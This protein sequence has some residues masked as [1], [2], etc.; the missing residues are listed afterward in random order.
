MKQSELFADAL[1]EFYET[2]RADLRVERDDGYRGIENVA[3]YFTTAREF[4]P[5]EKRA[6]KF[7]RGKILDAGCGAGRHSL[8][9]QKRGL[10]V[11]AVDISPR[12]AAL[13]RARGV[14]DARV[15]NL[16][17]KLPFADSQFDTVILFGNNLGIC[18]TLSRFQKMLRELHRIT[19]PRGRII[20][21]T[22]MPS[23]TNPIHKSYL[24]KNLERG[25]ALGQIR[26][27]LAHNGKRGAWF[28]LLLLAPTDLMQIAARAGWEIAAVIAEK[29]FEDGYA[30]VL[31]K[32]T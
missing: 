13:A 12:I 24:S 16:C 9:L 32:K 28:D 20:A 21:T 22:R 31:E 18:G 25:R 19:S 15:A 11:I 2:G 17:G 14:R 1:W 27:R 10:E 5:I 4:M 30:V 8:V 3:W 23:T 29:N 26:I 7:A 6:L